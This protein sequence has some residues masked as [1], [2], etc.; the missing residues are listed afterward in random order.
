VH[1]GVVCFAECAAEWSAACSFAIVGAD[2]ESTE[3][4]PPGTMAFKSGTH[5]GMAAREMQQWYAIVYT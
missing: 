5:F 3:P 1:C 4:G 2:V